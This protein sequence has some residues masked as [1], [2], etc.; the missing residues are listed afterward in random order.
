MKLVH[1]LDPFVN[2]KQL[3]C[4]GGRLGLKLNRNVSIR[5]V[6]LIADKLIVRN[7]WL[8]G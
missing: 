2:D 3:I 1:D 6:V 8:M 4:A 5:D 7:R